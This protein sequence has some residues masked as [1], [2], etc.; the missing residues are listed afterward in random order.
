MTVSPTG[1]QRPAERTFGAEET[2]DDPGIAAEVTTML[3]PT[4]LRLPD[5]DRPAPPEPRK[6]AACVQIS[7]DD[8]REL[9]PSPEQVAATDTPAAQTS[10][11]TADA[12]PTAFPPTAPP[13]TEADEPDADHLGPAPSRRTTENPA[14][15]G[16]QGSNR[17]PKRAPHRHDAIPEGRGWMERLRSRSIAILVLLSLAATAIVAGRKGDPRSPLDAEPDRELSVTPELPQSPEARIAV[18]PAIDRQ[19]TVSDEN[20]TKATRP[21]AMGPSEAIDPSPASG[22]AI[23]GL[24]GPGQSPR[25]A[26]RPDPANAP[27]A[28]DEP[29]T[30][31]STAAREAAPPTRPSTEP[32]WDLDNHAVWNTPENANAPGRHSEP[33]E[34]A[35]PGETAAPSVPAVGEAQAGESGLG[36]SGAPAAKARQSPA[37]TPPAGSTATSDAGRRRGPRY[38]DTPEP[39][40]DWRRYLPDPQTDYIAAPPQPDTRR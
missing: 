12:D 3:P 4:L 31:G 2:S 1:T 27:S 34:T 32:V 16:C 25:P 33:G 28:A 15:T 24:L 38:S 17:V 10:R 26:G 18:N 11:G 22:A 30:E 39:I 37:A 23:S 35:T 7:A 5:L 8:F 19:V 29:L 21:E 14:E 36:E 20:G 13:T 40:T 9:P 6:P